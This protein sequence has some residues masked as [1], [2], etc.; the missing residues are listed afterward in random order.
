MRNSWF[1]VILLVALMAGC[2]GKSSGTQDVAAVDTTLKPTVVF[3]EDSFDFGDI[4]EGE[5][6]AH[7]FFF[8]NEG[9][10]SV[11]IL[12]AIPSCGCTTPRFSK[13]PIAVGQQGQVEV[14][15]NTEGWMGYQTKQ[16][17]LKLN[18]QKGYSTVSFS[19]NVIE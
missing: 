15:F 1:F 13:E 12:D 19:A 9:P 7:T 8:K 18:T 17:T 16:V 14:L 10:G 2:K 4:K 6:V 5:T 11:I 3:T